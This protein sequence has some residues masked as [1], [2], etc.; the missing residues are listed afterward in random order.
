MSLP[1]KMSY[2]I[3]WSHGSACCRHVLSAEAEIGDVA[4]ALERIEGEGGEVVEV[5]VVASTTLTGRLVEE[6]LI[7]HTGGPL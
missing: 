1:K 5:E 3:I 4:E 6:W 7:N 2:N